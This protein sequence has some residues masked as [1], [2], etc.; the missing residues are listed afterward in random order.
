[1]GLLNNAVAIDA[2]VVTIKRNNATGTLVVFGGALIS[3]L[4]QIKQQT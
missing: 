1:M 2:E 4:K 3:H